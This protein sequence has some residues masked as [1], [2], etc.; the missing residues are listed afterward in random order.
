MGVIGLGAGGFGYSV[1]IFEIIA[2]SILLYIS[3]ELT[4]FTVERLHLIIS[5]S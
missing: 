3:M 1:F 2:A 5:L 4:I